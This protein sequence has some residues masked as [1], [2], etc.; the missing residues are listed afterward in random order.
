[1]FNTGY[2]RPMVKPEVKKCHNHVRVLF[3]GTSNFWPDRFTFGF[4]K[5]G[6]KWYQTTSLQ[7][8]HSTVQLRTS[9]LW[10]LPASIEMQVIR[11]KS[12][13]FILTHLL[14]YLFIHLPIS[15]RVPYLVCNECECVVCRSASPNLIKWSNFTNR[16][17][18]IT[19]RYKD[20]QNL[21][22]KKP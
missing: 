11:I 12:S 21:S 15:N 18:W 13:I 20:S 22:S 4:Y 6:P 1:M 9:K 10:N 5:K 8:R 7:N 3:K 16:M 2:W 19:N 17:S 14:I